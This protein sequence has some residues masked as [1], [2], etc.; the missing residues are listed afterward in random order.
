MDDLIALGLTSRPELASQQAQIQATLAS[1]KQERW[2]PLLPN[3][4]LRGASTNP[5]GTLAT[6]AFYPSPSNGISGFRGDVD[7]QIVWQLDNLG[8]GNRA[9][10]HQ[11]RAENRLAV[12]ELSRIQYQV[13]AEVA[14][15]HAQAVQASRRAV[16]VEKGLRFALLSADK[17]LD[18]LN[19]TKG[20][21][22]QMVTLVRRQEVVAAIQSLSQAYLDYFAAVADANRAPVSPVPGPGTARP[23]RDAERSG[24]AAT[25]RSR[26]DAVLLTA[27]RRNWRRR[28]VAV[29]IGSLA[30]RHRDS[31]QMW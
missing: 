3:I 5:G 6:G 16:V 9:T 25:S 27:V 1:I 15:A 30:S 12:V 7:L 26:A 19:Q 24:P 29:T 18:A 14:E 23:A 20:V 17:N 10:I 28:S 22:N 21:G 4:L 11:K 2:R 31:L 13:A 8:L